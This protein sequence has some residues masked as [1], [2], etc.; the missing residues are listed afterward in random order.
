[1]IAALLLLAACSV[2]PLVETGADSGQQATRLALEAGASVQYVLS[3]DWVGSSL[4]D[5]ARVFQTDLGYRVGL[6]RAYV[7]TIGVQLDPCELSG[8]RWSP[9]DLLGRPALADHATTADS[10]LVSAVLVEDLL[11]A[12]RVEFGIGGASGLEYCAVHWLTG[13][14]TEGG[15]G[16]QSVRLDGWVQAAG[17]AEA[18]ILEG[19]IW[20]SAGGLPDL[21]AGEAT[22]GVSSGEGLDAEVEIVRL[23]ARALDGEELSLLSDAEIAFAFLAGLGSGAEAR[24]WR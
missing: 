4:E 15:M 13:A 8:L 20:L 2:A 1:M 23:P 19:E 24:V 22:A 11:D 16:G 21:V 9:L 3:V 18:R 6:T 7:A 12:E 5:G 14:T 17:E 10:S